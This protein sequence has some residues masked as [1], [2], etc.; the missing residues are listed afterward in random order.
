MA[1]Q[2]G[3]EWE[4]VKVKACFDQAGQ[5]GGANLANSQIWN[6]NPP[7]G[8]PRFIT[9]ER[10]YVGGDGRQCLLNPGQT[11]LS[12]GL[13]DGVS[14]ECGWLN[15]DVLGDAI[16]NWR[17]TF[18]TG[19]ATWGLSLN[20]IT[21]AG[22]TT[23]TPSVMMRNRNLYVERTP[24]DGSNT[25]PNSATTGGVGVGPVAQRPPQCTPY[26][27]WWDDSTKILYQ[28]SAP[29]TW[30]EH[31]RQFP[32]PHPLTLVDT[33]SRNGHLIEDGEGH[34]SPLLHYKAKPVH[35]RRKR[36]K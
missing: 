23:Y 22:G 8:N 25:G 9:V 31:Y 5:G 17:N 19:S 12:C 28:C 11:S 10:C 7:T 13:V 34:I 21:A 29:N 27:G 2:A 36:T 4:I 18:T 16:Y 32:Y 1:A 6:Q 26:V 33:L 14:T 3:D 30:T 20:T 35:H 24:F 15:Q